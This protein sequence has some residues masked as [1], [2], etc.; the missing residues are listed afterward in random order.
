MAK[1]TTRTNSGDSK[2]YTPSGW[3]TLAFIGT[4]YGEKKTSIALKWLRNEA[5]TRRREAWD[6]PPP[7]N[8]DTI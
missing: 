4:I 3:E 8:D 2:L 1:T 5:K 7:T 6:L